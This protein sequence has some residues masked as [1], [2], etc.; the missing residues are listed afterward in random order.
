MNQSSAVSSLEEV[1]YHFFLAFSYE[2][3]FQKLL[4]IRK[5]WFCLLNIAIITI[6]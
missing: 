2:K 6:I 3:S 4:L 5:L 1:G